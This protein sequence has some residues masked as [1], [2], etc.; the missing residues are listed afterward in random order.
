MKKR[1]S[2]LM[3]SAFSLVR[4]VFVKL[5]NIRTFSSALVQ[6]FSFSTKFSMSGGGKINLMKK[7]HTKRNVVFE[8]DGGIIDIGEG[9]FFNNGSMVVAKERITIGKRCS[10]GPNVLI[11]DHDHNIHSEN[12]IHDSGFLTSPVVIGDNVWI[13]ANSVILRGSVIGSGCVVGAGS[14]IKGVYPQDT[15]IIQKR[16]E[17]IREKNALKGRGEYKFD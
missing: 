6:D 12:E 16:K 7:I 5:F 13:G 14:V 8:S 17:D 4:A 9:C 2:L 3:R 11:Y 15:V 10:F 1:I